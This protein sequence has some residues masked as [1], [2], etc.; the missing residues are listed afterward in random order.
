LR[1]RAQAEYV[2]ASDLDE[3]IMPFGNRSIYEL[4]QDYRWKKDSIVALVVR[5]SNVRFQ[6]MG[7]GGN[8]SPLSTPRSPP[9][10]S[11]LEIQ[12]YYGAMIIGANESAFPSKPVHSRGEIG[13][14]V[15]D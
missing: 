13:R 14:H 9:W 1:S 11:I 4:I 5:S 12:G 10:G 8:L 2:I 6:V 3:I 7:G 15:H